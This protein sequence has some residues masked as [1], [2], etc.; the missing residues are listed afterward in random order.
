[1]FL[2]RRFKKEIS[3]L[4]FK[5][6]TKTVELFFSVIHESDADYTKKENES[7]FKTI[8]RHSVSRNKQIILRAASSRRRSQKQSNISTLSAPTANDN[9]ALT[10]NN[11]VTMLVLSANTTV[12]NA[13]STIAAPAAE[14]AEVAAAIGA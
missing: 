1:M 6:Y 10:D 7:F 2:G 11:N 8:M 13:K 12:D 5:T 14:P 9:D 4:C 3:K